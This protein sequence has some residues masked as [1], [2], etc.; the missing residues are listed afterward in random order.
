MDW[1]DT[2]SSMIFSLGSFFTLSAPLE[3]NLLRLHS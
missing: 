2:G 3:D 1:H